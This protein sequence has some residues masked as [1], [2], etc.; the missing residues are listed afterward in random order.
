M[1]IAAALFA[2]AAAFTLSASAGLGGSLILV[3]ALSLLLGVKQGVALSA[4]ML[5]ANNV[6][7]VALYRRTIP[8]RAATG[9]LLAT[10]AGA[11]LGAR[12]LIVLPETVVAIAVMLGVATALWFELRRLELTSRVA[13]PVLAFFSGATSGF[14]G[15]SGPLKGVAIRNLGLDR[16]HFVGAAS[17]VS[18]GGDLTKTAIFASS[19]LLDRQALTIAAAAVPIM[20]LASFTGRHLNARVGESAFFALFWIVMAGYVVRLV[21]NVGGSLYEAS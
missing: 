21:W 12:L 15:T 14:S 2:A 7:K 13:S 16:M 11:L 5:A 18:L 19:G 17:I 6:F 3:P 20:F 9:V 8:W 4:L 1:I 10:I